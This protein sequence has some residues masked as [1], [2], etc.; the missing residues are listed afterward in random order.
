MEGDVLSLDTDT[1]PGEAL[2]VP[3]MKGGHRTGSSPALSGIRARAAK[4]LER[5]PEALRRLEPVAPYQVTVGKPL[6]E[7]AAEADRR[8]ARRATL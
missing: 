8:L 4:S 3:A 7:L 1:Q 5:L 2:L 6:I